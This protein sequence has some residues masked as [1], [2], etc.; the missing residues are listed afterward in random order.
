MLDVKNHFVPI[1]WIPQIRDQE[2]SRQIPR[3]SQGYVLTLGRPPR[4]YVSVKI[5][6]DEFDIFPH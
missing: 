5:C 3:D 1:L 2:V 6:C 4:G